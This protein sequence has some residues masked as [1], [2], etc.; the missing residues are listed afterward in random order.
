MSDVCTPYSHTVV[1]AFWS[2]MMDPHLIP[3]T[4]LS[5]KHHLH[6]DSDFTCLGRLSN[7]CACAILSVVLGHILQNFMKPTSLLVDSKT[8]T[9]IDAQIMHHFIDSHRLPRIIKWTHS[10]F[11][12]IMAAD[13]DPDHS[14]PVTLV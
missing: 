4:Q 8:I 12:P 6:Y 10:M 7:N 5:K 3:M 1:S 9:M 13:W 2:V 14:S 11:S